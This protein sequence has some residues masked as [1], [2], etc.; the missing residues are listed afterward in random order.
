MSLQLHCGRFTLSLSRPLIMGIINVT[1]DSFSDGGYFVTTHHAVEQGLRLIEDGADILDIGGES[2]RPGAQPVCLEEELKR[3]LPVVEQLVTQPIP[4]SVDTYKPEVMRQCLA[5]GASMIN[6]VKALREEG[7][8]NIVGQSRA[9][10][11][12]MHMQGDPQTMQLD[13]HYENVVSEVKTFLMERVEQAQA[14]GIGRERIVIDPGFGFG[15][16]LS[17]NL[18]LIRGLKQLGETGLPVL[19]GLSRKSVLGRIAGAEVKERASASVAAAVV[20]VMKGARIVRVHDV[21]ATRDALTVVGR[22]EGWA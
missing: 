2:T 14:A 20:A 21:R 8:L 22:V 11:C 12:L 4:L 10:V 18:D 7:A 15:K 5:A 16:N 17:H 13:P 3:V 19:A 6:D 9:A 1:P